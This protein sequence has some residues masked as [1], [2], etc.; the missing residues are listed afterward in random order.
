M[1]PL[2]HG[3]GYIVVTLLTKKPGT[4]VLIQIPDRYPGTKILESPST[5]HYQLTTPI[6]ERTL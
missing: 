4:R 6:C 2:G 1:T 5:V 3:L